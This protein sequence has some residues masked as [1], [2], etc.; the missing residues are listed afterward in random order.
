MIQHNIHIER[1]LEFAG[2]T[3]IYCDCNVRGASIANSFELNPLDRSVFLGTT[4]AELMEF[5]RDHS[6]PALNG[7][8]RPQRLEEFR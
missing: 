1:G 8:R 4:V 6:S 7:H 3:Y 5:F 2:E